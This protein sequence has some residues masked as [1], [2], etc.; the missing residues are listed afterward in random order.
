MIKTIDFSKIYTL[1]ILSLY[2]GEKINCTV[3][4]KTNIDNV[5]NNEDNYNIYERFFSSIGL[6]M[7]SYYSVIRPSTTIYICKLVES[8]EPLEIKDEKIFI[9]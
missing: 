1:S 7:T 9:P 5:A 6:G 4:G 3:I 8:L 2:G